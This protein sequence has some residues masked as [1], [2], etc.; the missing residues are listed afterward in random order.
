MSDDQAVDASDQIRLHQLG[1]ARGAVV[2][3][4]ARVVIAGLTFLVVFAVA[5]CAWLLVVRTRRG[6]AAATPRIRPG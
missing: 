6:W 2:N 5:G 3:G 1:P 4:G